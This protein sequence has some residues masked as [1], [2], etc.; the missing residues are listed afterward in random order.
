MQRIL[1][2]LEH[3]MVQYLI[4]GFLGMSAA[5][6]LF[7]IGGSFAKVTGQENTAVG[8]SFEAGGAFAGFLLVFLL[9]AS[10][11]ARLQRIQQLN[12][13]FHPR[14]HLICKPRFSQVAQYQCRLTLY[15]EESGARR[16]T[17]AEVWWDAGHL[18]ITVRDAGPNDM[19]SVRLESG[20]QIWESGVFH[21]GT[22]DVSMS[23]L[24]SS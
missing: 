22:R 1:Q 20:T 2:V 17:P 21:L 12:R 7:E 19:V 23:L 8:V 18:T 11:I 24:P 4:V 13:Q 9:S 14:I 3:F 10:V 16:E 6:L 15:N 5:L